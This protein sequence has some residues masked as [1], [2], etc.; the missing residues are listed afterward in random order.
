MLGLGRNTREEVIEGGL[1]DMDRG[2]R[3]RGLVNLGGG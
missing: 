1:V 2:G 3:R